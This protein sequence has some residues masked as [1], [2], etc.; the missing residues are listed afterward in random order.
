MTFKIR[1]LCQREPDS[2]EI[3][4]KIGDA[5][6]GE[7]LTQVAYRAGVVIQQ[8]CGGTPSCTDCK[9]VV[10]EGLESG[11]EPPTGPELR[12]MG[13]VSHLTRERLSCQSI[14]KNCATVYVPSPAAA[15]RSRKRPYQPS[16]GVIENG[17]EK[18]GE[19]KNQKSGFKKGR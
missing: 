3:D 18:K 12:L 2:T 19:Q 9:V 6:A 5:E 13:N 10:R 8:T 14:V 7:L 4:E 15:R 11:F 17:Q 16:K 1:F